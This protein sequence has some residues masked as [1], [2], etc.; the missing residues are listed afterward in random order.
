[1]RSCVDQP[2]CLK[3]SGRCERIW[4]SVRPPVRRATEG[5]AA[6][7]GSGGG[8]GPCADLCAGHDR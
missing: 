3:S 7:R 1:M 6:G 4:G 2:D 8:A 5:I